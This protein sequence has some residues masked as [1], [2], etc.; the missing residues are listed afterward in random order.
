MNPIEIKEK[1]GSGRER[2][3]YILYYMGKDIL[4]TATA[5]SAAECME[6]WNEECRRVP[7]SKLPFIDVE[8][9]NDNAN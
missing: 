2:V 5:P 6:R 8:L 1:D 3:T 9:L 4:V 7:P